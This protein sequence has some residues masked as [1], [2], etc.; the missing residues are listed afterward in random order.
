MGIERALA[1]EARAGD[2]TLF[3]GSRPCSAG[4]ARCPSAPQAQPQG[5]IKLVADDV[6]RLISRLTFANRRPVPAYAASAKEFREASWSAALLRRFEL[7]VVEVGRA[8]PSAPK[9]NRNLRRA[10]TARPTSSHLSHAV[11]SPDTPTQTARAAQASKRTSPF[12][13]RLTCTRH[14]C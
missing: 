5:A 10:G 6:R 9:T 8:L 12:A 13:H 1:C 2:S 11:S 14:A 4:R 3:C 7:F